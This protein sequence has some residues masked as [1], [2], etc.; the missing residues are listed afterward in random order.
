MLLNLKNR[1]LKKGHEEV[2]L[3]IFETKFL[4][5]LSN[6]YV[7]SYEELVE[8]TDSLTKNSLQRLYSRLKNKVNIKINT[9]ANIGYRLE[10]VIY[11]TC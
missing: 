5:A 3:T 10:E 6:N 9:V 11:I 4:A 1:M 8:F 2:H 7:I